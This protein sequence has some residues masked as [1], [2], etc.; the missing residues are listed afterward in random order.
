MPHLN[1]LLGVATVAAAGLFVA[2]AL[3]PLPNVP[4]KAA[5][6]AASDTRVT[7]A[8]RERDATPIVRLPTIEVVARR[9]NARTSS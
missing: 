4:R 8:M 6:P 9:S 1:E 5:A 7:S 2:T 3:Q